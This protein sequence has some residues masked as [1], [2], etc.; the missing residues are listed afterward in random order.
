MWD[1]EG[2]HITTCV[3]ELCNICAPHTLSDW[4]RP[5]VGSSSQLSGSNQGGG[6]GLKGPGGG[7]GGL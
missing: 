7:E 6:Q 2:V 5:A 3:A 1:G 4:Q